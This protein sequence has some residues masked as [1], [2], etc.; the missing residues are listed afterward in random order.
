M[1]DQQPWINNPERV[2]DPRTVRN[3]PFNVADELPMYTIGFVASISNLLIDEH[4]DT[5]VLSIAISGFIE[6]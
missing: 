1:N 6:Y 2:N 4:R 3:C 5:N